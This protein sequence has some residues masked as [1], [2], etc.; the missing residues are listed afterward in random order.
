MGFGCHSSTRQSGGA[1]AESSRRPGCAG[2]RV[3]RAE[4]VKHRRSSGADWPRAHRAFCHNTPAL[5]G[6][7]PIYSRNTYA[8]ALTGVSWP[9]SWSR[10]R[11][12]PF[13]RTN[14]VIP[15]ARVSHDHHDHCIASRIVGISRC[16]A[17]FR[18]HR[19][20]D[21]ARKQRNSEEATRPAF[22]QGAQ[23]IAIVPRAAFRGRHSF[24]FLRARLRPCGHRNNE[25]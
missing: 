5:P 18:L 6:I 21:L 19:N 12:A 3:R 22:V 13:S 25:V 8:Q 14:F 7:L 16:P 9:L 10:A 24:A 1:P 20:H 2:T 11:L 15:P 4:C 17:A 23:P